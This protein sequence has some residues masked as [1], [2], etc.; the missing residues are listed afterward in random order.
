MT[1]IEFEVMAQPGLT[2]ITV[3]GEIDVATASWFRRDVL[4]RLSRCSPGTCV[5]V[6]LSR[7][8]FLDCAAVGAMIAVHRRAGLL[9]IEL[10]LA[11]PRSG[12]SKVLSLTGT[13]RLIDVYPTL[14]A[15]LAHRRQERS[16]VALASGSSTFAVPA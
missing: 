11:G 2:V 3:S 5:I 4:A 10:C 6:D 14:E 16:A 7:V 8:P 1:D 15:A 9:G 12:P 13:D